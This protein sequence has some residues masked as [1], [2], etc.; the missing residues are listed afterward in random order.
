[1]QINQRTKKDLEFTHEG[2]IAK[3][4]TPIQELK[5]SV[6]ACL[7]WEGSFYESGENVANRIKELCKKVTLKEI[8]ALAIEAR[9]KMNLRHVPLLLVREMA[10][11]SKDSIIAETLCRVIQRPDELTEFL[12]LYWSE[13]KA[14]LSAQAKKGLARALPK[15][16]AY[17]LAK[18]NRDNAIKLRDVLFLCHAKPKDK[19]QEVAWKKLVV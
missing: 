4:I 19:E 18:Y 16:S 1:M 8:A 17:Q 7:L 5:R 9:E 11:S 15:F 13:G 10:R 3:R 6:M 14:P 12:A 2:A